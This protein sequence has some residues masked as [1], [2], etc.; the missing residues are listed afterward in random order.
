LPT[1]FKGYLTVQLLYPLVIGL[2]KLSILAFYWRLF[3]IACETR[4]FIISLAVVVLIWMIVV[5]FVMLFQYHPIEG[6]WNLQLPNRECLSYHK[7]YL[8]SAIPNISTDFVIMVIPI[9]YILRLHMRTDHRIGL[10]G[11]FMLGGL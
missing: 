6:A 11:T 9:P 8:G 5:A 2:V 1:F 4:V 10:I 3:S 7:Y